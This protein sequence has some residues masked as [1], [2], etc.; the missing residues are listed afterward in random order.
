MITKKKVFIIENIE[1]ERVGLHDFLEGLGFEVYSAGNAQEAR[2]LADLYWSELD[3]AILDM[4]LDDPDETETTGAD[5]AMEFR[6]K[7]KSFPP[8]S[9]IYSGSNEIDYYRLALKLGAAAYLLKEE[10]AADV[11]AQHV[12]IL[13][14]R[15]ALNGENPKIAAEVAQ[16]AVHSRSKSD[17]IQ[18]FCRRVLKPEFESCLGAGFVILFTEGN[19]TRN[20]ADNAG[21]PAGSSAL[22]HTLQA[23]AHGKGN[24][25][26]PFI[27]ETR[28]LEPPPD[29]ETSRLYK[30]LNLAAF[31]PLS[32]SND[33]RLSIGILQPKAP[34]DARPPKDAKTLCTLLA[35]YLRPTVLENV[36]NIWSQW[37]EL[38]A[39]R[40][41]T[42][43]LCLSV[44]QE[45]NDGV[46]TEDLVQLE[47][48]ANDLNDT[49]QYLAQLENRNWQDES[50][51]I[52]IN[53]LVTE[54][55]KYVSPAKETSE[56]KIDLRGDCPMRAQRSDLEIVF[57]RLL[58]WFVYRS[59]AMPLDVETVIKI[60][61]EETDGGATVIFEDNSH[62]LP[63]KL[64][65]DLFAPF[66]QAISTPFAEIDGARPG[67]RRDEAEGTTKSHLNTG[68]YLPLYLAKMLVE[69]RYHG[70]LQDHSDEITKHPYGHRILMQL[71]APN[72]TGQH[73]A[74]Q[75]Q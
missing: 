53:D 9:L 55:W 17:A 39:T 14:L 11:V 46:E 24:L 72:T 75:P 65:E 33:L 52:S 21:L 18:T 62:R 71:P 23:L 25:T 73:D 47:D 60:K 70:L 26:E 28:E 3:V 32:L 50:E 67:Q 37:T 54:T 45:I 7:M 64:R 5:I 8:E 49:G 6:K 35:Q 61:C 22:Y 69:G 51:A 36:L 68:R 2:T 12:R 27:L 40:T 63:K 48:L 58:Q 59:R 43:K 56:I 44:G 41:S 1:Q 15:R 30:K 16:I 19:T 38:R 10:A 20:C 29:Q 4:S 66:T 31:L 74:R 34:D 42:A 57:S 13:A